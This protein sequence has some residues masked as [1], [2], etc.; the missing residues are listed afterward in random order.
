[1]F[2]SSSSSSSSCAIGVGVPVIYEN[3]AKVETSFLTNLENSQFRSAPSLYQSV[4]E[5]VARTKTPVSLPSYC[6]PENV[7]T[8]PMLD[9]FSKYGIDYR[10]EK[11]SCKHI[12]ALD[13]QKKEG[14]SI[15]GAGYLISE[16][17]AAEK[18]AAKVWELS[19]RETE[20]IKTL[21]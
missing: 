1:M 20:I 16:K 4:Q 8:S 10:V 19:E 14:K 11:E 13:S 5:A 9:R 15:F 18:A 21:K 3:G 6:Y 2:S 17:A 7:I 12:R